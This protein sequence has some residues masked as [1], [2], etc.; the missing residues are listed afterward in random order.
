M[1]QVKKSMECSKFCSTKASSSPLGGVPIL[2][3][4]PPIEAA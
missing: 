2:V 1:S 4:M 3:P